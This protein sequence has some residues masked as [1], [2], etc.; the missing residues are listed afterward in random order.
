M[1]DVSL[2]L[3]LWWLE[4][5]LVAADFCWSVDVRFAPALLAK[6]LLIK[7][8]FGILKAV[9]GGASGCAGLVHSGIGSGF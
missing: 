7:F 5:V 9:P 2:W 1:A 8:A 3:A 4:A 6:N